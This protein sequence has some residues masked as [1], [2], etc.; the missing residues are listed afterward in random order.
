M[1]KKKTLS[2]LLLGM[3]FSASSFAQESVNASGND[4]TGVGGSVAYSIGQVTYNEY[5]TASGSVAQGVQHAYEIVT[6]S[7]TEVPISIDVNAYPNPTVDQLFLEV[8]DASLINMTFELRDMNGKVLQTSQVM[9]KSTKILMGEYT[10]AVYFVNVYSTDQ[11]PIKSFK[12]IK[13]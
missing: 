2:M 8:S 12:I 4:V 6:L 5:A 11:Q 9:E 10:P 1:N 3:S 7:F 13:N